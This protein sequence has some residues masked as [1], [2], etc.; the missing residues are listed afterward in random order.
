M[1]STRSREGADEDREGPRSMSSSLPRSEIHDA[2]RELAL[3]RPEL[4]RAIARTTL[5]ELHLLAL[6]GDPS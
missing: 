1:G 6:L 4:A 5:G 3:A 2:E